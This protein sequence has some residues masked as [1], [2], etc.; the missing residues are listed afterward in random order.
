MGSG[1]A[2]SGEEGSGPPE[3]TGATGNSTCAPTTQMVPLFVHPANAYRCHAQQD[4]NVVPNRRYR[5]KSVLNVYVAR[6]EIRIHLV[7]T[8]VH[9]H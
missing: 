9:S 6:L 2:I 7:L 3:R 1:T 8:R 5:T 4:S